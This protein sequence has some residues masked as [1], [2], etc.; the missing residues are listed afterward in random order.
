MI[1]APAR[2]PPVAVS[3][4]TPWG[5]RSG[6]FAAKA[7]PGAKPTSTSTARRWSAGR[8]LQKHPCQRLNFFIPA[9]IPVSIP[10]RLTAHRKHRP[11]YNLAH[12]SAVSYRQSIQIIKLSTS[13]TNQQFYTAK[14]KQ[15]RCAK[16]QISLDFSEV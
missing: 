16:P 13:A 15:M 6:K 9:N 4:T 11:R 2:Q 3:S 5:A 14:L 10:A 1:A 12:V 8:T 7:T